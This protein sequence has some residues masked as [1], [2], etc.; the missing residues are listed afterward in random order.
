VIETLKVME[1]FD[2][3]LHTHQACKHT[4]V[5]TYIH[6]GKQMIP[7][8]LEGIHDEGTPIR[9]GNWETPRSVLKKCRVKLEQGNG[10]NYKRDGTAQSA[11]TILRQKKPKQYTNQWCRGS[12]ENDADST[13]RGV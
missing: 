11:C 13:A 4:Y 7:T 5:Q 8:V 2:K 6:T 1:R 3:Y 9:G 10:T 12:N